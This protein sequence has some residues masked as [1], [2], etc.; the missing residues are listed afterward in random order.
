MRRLSG[1][2]MMKGKLYTSQIIATSSRVVE[3]FT[4]SMARIASEKNCKPCKLICQSARCFGL[5][6]KCVQDCDTM[7]CRMEC[8]TSHLPGPSQ[9]PSAGLK[10]WMWEKAKRKCVGERVTATTDRTTPYHYHFAVTKICQ[11][12]AWWRCFAC[13]LCHFPF[14]CVWDGCVKWVSL[15]AMHSYIALFRKFCCVFSTRLR[16]AGT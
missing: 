15:V 8:G 7:R 16:F 11:S 3:H 1:R 2:I 5:I 12:S 6:V 14:L 4:R 10:G 9:S 13:V